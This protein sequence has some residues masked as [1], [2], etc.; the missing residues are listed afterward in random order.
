MA[1]DPAAHHA[2]E[3]NAALEKELLAF[4]VPKDLVGRVES[5][6]AQLNESHHGASFTRSHVLRMLIETALAARAA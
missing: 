5:Y 3:K 4:R 6:R 2:A 1:N